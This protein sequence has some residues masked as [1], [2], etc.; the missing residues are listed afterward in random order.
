MCRIRKLLLGVAAV[1]AFVS[2]PAL[3][4]P[5][6]AGSHPHQAHHQRQPSRY[7]PHR[8]PQ[9]THPNQRV[10]GAPYTVYYRS[11]PSAT[12]TRHGDYSSHQRAVEALNLLRER[13]YEVFSR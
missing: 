2:A 4:S 13:G 9:H 10:V 6:E 3:V 11:S 1:V 12:W 5:V 8:P 7:V